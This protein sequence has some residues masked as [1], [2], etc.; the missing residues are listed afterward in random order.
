VLV[1]TGLR[2]TVVRKAPLVLI[3]YLIQLHLLVVAVAVLAHL[4]LVRLLVQM[5]VLVAVLHT[6]PAGLEQ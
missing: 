2:L 1:E 3:Q 6:Q 4:L 5:V